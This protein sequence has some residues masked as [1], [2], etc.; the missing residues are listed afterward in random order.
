MMKHLLIIFLVAISPLALANEIEKTIR[1]LGV[2]TDQ[3]RAFWFNTC[4]PDFKM[5]VPTS[6]LNNEKSVVGPGIQLEFIASETVNKE[7]I[8]IK[9]GHICEAL[10]RYYFEG[11]A[12]EQAIHPF[13]QADQ[14]IISVYGYSVIDI[15]GLEKFQSASMNGKID[16]FTMSLWKALQ[17]KGLITIE[18]EESTFNGSPSKA[19]FSSVTEK[20]KQLN[21]A[22]YRA[23]R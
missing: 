12:F 20:G 5:R 11:S 13:I 21:K 3:F 19:Y 4:D 2:T 8:I 1:A 6:V 16:T 22:L 10:R 23:D 17:K 9:S 7:E 14:N 15:L 18:H